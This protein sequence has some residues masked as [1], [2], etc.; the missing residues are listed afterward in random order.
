MTYNTIGACLLIFLLPL[1][2]HSRL[3]GECKNGQQVIS[4]QPAIYYK[5][6]TDQQMLSAAQWDRVEKL[7]QAYVERLNPEGL[8][9]AD[10]IKRW[11]LVDITEHTMHPAT[12]LVA[13]KNDG[14]NGHAFYVNYQFIKKA[15]LLQDRVR[16]VDLEFYNRMLRVERV[17]V[18]TP[19]RALDVSLLFLQAATH[20]APGLFI[21]VINT[22]SDIPGP[23]DKANRFGGIIR[24]GTDASAVEEFHNKVAELSRKVTPP[25]YSKNGD[26]YD[27]SFFTWDPVSGDV[28]QWCVTVSSSGISSLSRKLTSN[29]V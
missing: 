19:S 29:R 8:L 26:S 6:Y 18:E 17:L 10:F 21:R 23:Q 24:D 14:S 3:E 11:K 13:V 1:V 9:E 4:Y 2:V 16:K 27:L 28:E 20:R 15:G 5:E 7:G 12:A 22:A 25:C